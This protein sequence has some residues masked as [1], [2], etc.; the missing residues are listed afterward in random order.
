M[1]YSKP[2][3]DIIR[4]RYSCRNY[5]E[6]PI[7]E[8]KRRALES[9][10]AASQTGP[11][12][13]RARFALVAATAQDRGAL[14]GLGTYGFIKG[15]TGFIIGAVKEPLNSME[16]FGYLMER[17]ILYA[18]DVGLGTCWLGGTFTK[19]RFARKI[20]AGKDESVPAVTAVGYIGDDPQ[21]ERV[22]RRKGGARRFSWDRL[23]FDREFGTPLTREAAGPYA[24]PLEMVWLGPS[25]SNNQ[26]WR[27]VRDG[28]VYHLYIQR[29]PG[30]THSPL[31]KLIRIADMQRIDAGIA[32]SHFELAADEAGLEGK[33]EVSEPGIARPDKL[34]EYVASWVG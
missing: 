26:P 7:E 16:D 17:I 4:E 12:G 13:T 19:S 24:T 33:W 1:V 30:Y 8:E 31:M 6:R 25:A 34:T 3:T 27:I 23:F 28:N 29:T 20:A 22:L 2:V 18:T 15:A 11:M 9:F 10:V 32:M 5:L 14:K 21:D